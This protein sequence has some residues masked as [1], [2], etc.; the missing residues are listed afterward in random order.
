MTFFWAFMSAVGVQIFFEI[1]KSIFTK[2]EIIIDR[3]HDGE[4][5]EDKKMYTFAGTWFGVS[6][7]FLLAPFDDGFYFW[8]GALG[9]LIPL[10]LVGLFL[11]ADLPDLLRGRNSNLDLKKSQKL[12]EKEVKEFNEN[13]ESLSGAEIFSLGFKRSL[14]SFEEGK[15]YERVLDNSE[16]H[17]ELYDL[18]VMYILESFTSP[19]TDGS[20]QFP[21]DLGLEGAIELN[22]RLAGKVFDSD[23]S[24]VNSLI[25]KLQEELDNSDFKNKFSY[26]WNFTTF[27]KII[28]SKR[29]PAT[30]YLIINNDKN[31][32]SEENF[33]NLYDETTKLL[34]EDKL[35]FFENQLE[36][37]RLSIIDNAIKKIEKNKAKEKVT[38]N[39][40]EPYI[41]V[42]EMMMGE[43]D[44][45]KLLQAKSFLDEALERLG[46]GKRTPTIKQKLESIERLNS[47]FDN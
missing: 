13:F 21:S 14:R 37:H 45:I 35:A 29:N 9:Y 23:P 34:S 26:S 46:E 12:E 1:L 18:F 3:L 38:A 36:K 24:D 5:S 47:F 11:L 43:D 28:M 20:I 32:F 31:N 19:F 39:T 44:P 4:E 2:K 6:T 7:F 22:E 25:Q 27:Q 15:S 8:I 10:V 40:L 33:L 41:E 16:A 30:F 17:T 42:A